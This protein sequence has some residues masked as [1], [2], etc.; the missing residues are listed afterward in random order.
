MNDTTSAQVVLLYILRNKLAAR[1]KIRK[2]TPYPKPHVRPVAGNRSE[3]TPRH[4]PQ[5]GRSQFWRHV[6][7]QRHDVTD[8]R[9]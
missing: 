3:Q 6:A 4:N 1:A 9:V 5:E 7:R 8:S 2:K